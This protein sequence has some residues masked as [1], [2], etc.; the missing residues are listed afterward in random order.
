MGRLFDKKAKGMPPEQPIAGGRPELADEALPQGGA[1]TG[2]AVR[3][4]YPQDPADEGEPRA[5]AQMR[6]AEEREHPG[7]T[8]EA[9]RRREEPEQGR[10]V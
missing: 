3:G 6:D 4:L 2:A 10:G 1:E 9:R 7:E 8:L 5:R